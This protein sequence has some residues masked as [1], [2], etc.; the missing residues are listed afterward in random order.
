M[1]FLAVTITLAAAV[2]ADTDDANNS[3]FPS[4]YSN[5]CLYPNRPIKAC[6]FPPLASYFAGHAAGHYTG[7]R[8]ADADDYYY[9]GY[10]V[11]NPYTRPYRAYVGYPTYGKRSAD[12]E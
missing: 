5:R 9:D 2:S 8:S 4:Y 1:K 6:N 10:Y 12:A 11:T 7:K 3:P